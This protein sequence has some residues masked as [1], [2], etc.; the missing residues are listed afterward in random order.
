MV[1]VVDLKR[2]KEYKEMFESEK[3][4]FKNSSYNTFSNSY[5]KKSSDPYMQRM[6]SNLDKIY[7][8]INSAYGTIKKWWDEYIEN[9]EEVD[10]KIVNKSSLSKSIDK[11]K[12]DFLS[13]I[14]DGVISKGFEE[15]KNDL[16]KKYEN[17]NKIALEN[18]ELAKAI[19]T[20]MREH[21]E[22]DFESYCERC[23]N[24]PT[25]ANDV[26]TAA[27]II[28]KQKAEEQYAKD[29]S[30]KSSKFVKG[31]SKFFSGAKEIYF[32]TGEN[33]FGMGLNLVNGAE[34]GYKNVEG[35]FNYA[36]YRTGLLD[37]QDYIELQEDKKKNEWFDDDVVND[38]INNDTSLNDTKYSKTVNSIVG[39]TGEQILPLLMSA[40]LGV[41]GAAIG[42]TING[43]G[44]GAD[45]SLEHQKEAMNGTP[46][47]LSRDI[48]NGT[49]TYLYEGNKI[50]FDSTGN[51][52]SNIKMEESEYN[53]ILAKYINEKDISK[54]ALLQGAWGALSWGF[55]RYLAGAEIVAKPFLNATIKIGIDTSMGGAETPI[56]AFIQSTYAKFYVDENGNKVYY[57][58]DA[59]FGDKFKHAFSENGGWKSVAEGAAMA[60]AMSTV[61]ESADLSKKMKIQEKYKTMID[62]N[63]NA[64]AKKLTE[65]GLSEQEAI[66]ALNKYS[67]KELAEK[68]DK[69]EEFSINNNK[70]AFDTE[71]EKMKE[72]IK[73]EKSLENVKIGSDK[74]DID[75]IWRD[76][77]K[78]IYDEEIMELYTKE[79]IR[80]T[81]LNPTEELVNKYYLEIQNGNY[82]LITD[83]RWKKYVEDAAKYKK[84]IQSR[85]IECE[86]IIGQSGLSKFDEYMLAKHKEFINNEAKHNKSIHNA[87]ECSINEYIQKQK[88]TPTKEL[89]DKL[90]KK[91]YRDI[92][93][94]KFD[95]ILPRYRNEV[96]SAEKYKKS[97]AYEKANV[98]KYINK[99]ILKKNNVS[100]EIFDKF[101]DLSWELDRLNYNRKNAG[102]RINWNDFK[103]KRFV[104]KKLKLVEKEL[105]D[106]SKEKLSKL[107]NY[108][109][110][111]D[112]NGQQRFGANQ[113]IIQQLDFSDQMYLAEKVAKKYG[114]SFYD[115]TI[116]IKGIDVKAGVCTY[117]AAANEIF[118]YYIDNP[119]KFAND[120]GFSMF[121]E[122]NGVKTLNTEEL[123]MDLYFFV[124]HENNG[125][126]L[127]KSVVGNKNKLTNEAIITDNG[128]NVLN[129]HNQV[130]LSFFEGEN[131][132]TL[133]KYLKSKDI[134]LEYSSHVIVSNFADSSCPLKTIS[135][136]KSIIN[137]EIASGN[138]LIINY[139]TVDDKNITMINLSGGP[140]VS[141]KTWGEGSGH[142]VFITRVLNDGFEVSSWGQKYKIKFSELQK[143]GFNILNCSIKNGGK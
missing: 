74:V 17:Y 69:L 118:S 66:Y 57:D 9:I 94:Q 29:H 26:M 110:S 100:S 63:P 111:L 77:N 109:E 37:A 4:E 8:N 137:K 44:K 56:Q 43:I 128:V 67:T 127:I 93:I 85:K 84:S 61:G 14:N 131:G 124:N 112:V 47:E 20:I 51:V 10:K 48:E 90:Y 119:A 3:K 104:R 101:D 27:G 99:N 24:S 39:S 92:Q 36:F 86:K 105:K 82:S 89:H 38:F 6:S 106:I 23:K 126:R 143:I 79:A 68:A 72:G 97:I 81:L 142:A 28:E 73:V 136:A 116:L 87:I 5:I 96:F 16:S 133:N 140:N 120:F 76:Y 54:G 71:L 12:K 117:A 75:A 15:M 11:I 134:N 123:I 130:Y 121:K 19:T 98:D 65:F 55:G 41:G 70:K 102:K 62:E 33:L 59:S 115:S 22:Y 46:T 13:N 60:A 25:F 2:I 125:G 40:V 129:S 95:K 53:K 31:A 45:D 80:K 108:F 122:V 103:Y 1:N 114:L 135:S 34:K 139:R 35:F 132:Y 138:T 50:V 64:A 49:I 78:I 21:P 18:P 7:L 52:V 88:L 42:G 32:D 58:K 83:G 30:V 113:G 141:T 91:Y 107:T